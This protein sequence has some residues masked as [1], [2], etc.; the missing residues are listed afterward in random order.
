MVS[1]AFP[2]RA[3]RLSIPRGSSSNDMDNS[4]GY[5]ILRISQWEWRLPS[6]SRRIKHFQ[7]ADHAFARLFS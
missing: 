3:G 7:W 1:K 4:L 5:A 2:L 6:E